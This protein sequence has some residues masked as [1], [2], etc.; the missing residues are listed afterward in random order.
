MNSDTLRGCLGFYKNKDKSTEKNEAKRG[1]E[2]YFLN[3]TFD[4]SQR[5]FE[6]P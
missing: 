3:K 5:C 1:E 6:F 4:G 2:A